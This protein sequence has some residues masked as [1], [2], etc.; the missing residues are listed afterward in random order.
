MKGVV[1]RLF[2]GSR[3]KEA[4][5]PWSPE[6]I[7]DQKPEERYISCDRVQWTY[8]CNIKVYYG[9]EQQVLPLTVDGFVLHEGV[10]Y[11]DFVVYADV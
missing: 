4:W 8:G 11:G 2:N 10:F 3:T 6:Y 9:D 5:N 1:L 7:D